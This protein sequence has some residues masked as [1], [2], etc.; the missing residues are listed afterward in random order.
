MLEVLALAAALM[1]FPDD[2]TDAVIVEKAE[3]MNERQLLFEDHGINSI[4]ET[5]EKFENSI[6]KSFLV[7][8]F[9][10]FKTNQI[11]SSFNEHEPHAA[12]SYINE[13]T[14]QIM[15]IHIFS[16]SR[17]KKNEYSEITKLSDSTVAI[18]EHDN[19][20]RIANS[21]IFEKDGLEYRI[22]IK[23]GRLATLDTLKKVANSFSKP[24]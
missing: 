21:L 2:S 4:N 9:I 14:G 12:I 18:Y 15:N 5:L 17:F 11:D 24:K 13:K 23:K 3:F 20:N 6:H 1:G 16:S 7:P 10:P 19:P 8:T 22:G